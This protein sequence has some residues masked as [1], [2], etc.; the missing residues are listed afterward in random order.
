MKFNYQATPTFSQVHADP[1]TYLFIKGPVGCVTGDTMVRVYRS[2]VCKEVPIERLCKMFEGGLHRQEEVPMYT[3]AYCG[4]RTMTF[5][6]IEDVI[7]SGEKEV[8]ELKLENGRHITASS[9]HEMLTPR[10]FIPLEFL[11]I[12]DKLLCQR[13]DNISRKSYKASKIVSIEYKGIQKTYDLCC[14]G[15]NHNFLA[16]G[17]IIHNSGKSS[18]CIWHLF[19]NALNQEPDQMGVR[20]PRYA[21]VRATY[22]ALKSTT[23]KSWQAWF[24]PLINIVYD[25][26]IRGEINLPLPD[27]TKLKMELV[28]IALDKAEEVNKL[29]S[30]ELTGAHINEAAECDLAI[31]QMLKSRIGRWPH[32]NVGD[33]THKFIIV[34][35]NSVDTEHQL[36]KLAE[37]DRPEQHSFYSQPPAVLITDERDGEV[38]DAAGNYYKIN[39]EAENLRGYYTDSKLGVPPSYYLDQIAGAEPDWISV[40]LMNNYGM[41][42]YGKPV[43]PQYDDSSHYANKALL[44]LKGVP[45]IIGMDCGLCYTDDHEILTKDGWKYFKDINKDTDKVA[46]RNP[47]TG[48]MTYTNINFKVDEEHDGDMI[49]WETQNMSMCV[50]PEHIIPVRNR[51]GKLM[52]RSAEWL[53]QHDSG[54]YFVDAVSSWKGKSLTSN[55]T[56]LNI[57]P[58]TYIQFMGW[59]LSEGC[60]STRR[61]RVKIAQEDSD[62]KDILREVLSGMS[63]VIT[64]YEDAQGFRGSNKVLAEYLRQFGKSGDKYVPQCIKDA[65]PEDIE[66]F[67]DTYILGDGCWKKRDNCNYADKI[68]YTKSKRMADDIQELTQKIGITSVI[69]ERPP[70]STTYIDKQGKRRVINS[71]LSYLI[72]FKHKHNKYGL[73]K[74]TVKQEYHRR[75]HYKG[76]RYCVN[77]PYHTLLVRRHG[78]IHWNGNTPAAAFMQLSPTGRLNVLDEIVTEDCSIKEFCDM[79]L[80]PKLHNEYRDLDYT[81]IAD[82]AI[83]QRSSNDAKSAFEIVKECG[84]RVRAASTNNELARRESVIYFLRNRDGFKLSL[85]APKLRKGFISEYHYAKIR[86]ANTDRYRET[87]DKNIYSHVHDA[88]QYGALEIKGGLGSHKSTKRSSTRRVGGDNKAGY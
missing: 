77:V 12:E 87:P 59:Y 15:P 84:L 55:D 86:A 52:F 49:E 53:E 76:R 50:T 26:P 72:R 39:P 62:N 25:T 34:D 64:W 61:N 16:N 30:L 81:I 54:Q 41:S 40:F 47:S 2:D 32:P 21:V 37:V 83:Y 5:E 73:R 67:L 18:G 33:V 79:L 68:I 82:P 22:P 11:D 28:F 4:Q 70:K 48:E 74:N 20:N 35:Y 45:L 71:N 46:T 27:N 66:L 51:H 60:V 65:S 63:D 58:K 38:K 1:N 88:L 29:Q 14:K 9:N 10:G 13:Y 80:W 17:I 85:N 69:K 36:Y 31:L 19:L 43:Y 8:Y 3:L 57:D 44:P 75:V 7:Y 6:E 56:L 24:G 23:V 42:R 78:K